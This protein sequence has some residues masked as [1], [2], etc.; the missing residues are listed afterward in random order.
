MGKSST[1]A[2]PPDKEGPPMACGEPGLQDPVPSD[3]GL[4]DPVTPEVGD[5]PNLGVVPEDPNTY[6]LAPC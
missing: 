1:R 5:P 4:C 3:I 6:G 2:S